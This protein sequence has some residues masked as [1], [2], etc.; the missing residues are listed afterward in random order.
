M[1]L[2][3]HTFFL[4]GDTVQPIRW[5]EAGHAFLVIIATSQEKRDNIG[6]TN[7]AMYPY[8]QLEMVA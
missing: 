4:T 7:R 2:N 6:L 8:L 5:V 1:D 3:E